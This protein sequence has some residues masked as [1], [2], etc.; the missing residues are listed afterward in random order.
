MPR[1]IETTVFSYAELGPKA[2]KKAKEWLSHWLFEGHEPSWTTELLEEDLEHHYG[3]SPNYSGSG[4]NHHPD[5]WW[6]YE[7][8]HVSFGACLDFKDLA[9]ADGCKPEASEILILVGELRAYD[10][11]PSVTFKADDRNHGPREIEVE[12]DDQ[13]PC[14][15]SDLNDY[16]V[17][18]LEDRK[19]TCEVRE[20]LFIE[21]AIDELENQGLV[22]VMQNGSKVE[23]TPGNLGV[24]AFSAYLDFVQAAEGEEAVKVPRH[25]LKVCSPNGEAAKDVL[26]NELQAAVKDWARE[27]CDGLRE[28]VDAEY[29]QF[30]DDDYLEE[31]FRDHGDE[32]E[33]T[34]DGE[35]ED[36]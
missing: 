27:V 36:I 23:A 33:F 1:V 32:F 25:A 28:T 18:W 30:S 31:Y 17:T 3:V 10:V 19:E 2:Q 11:E 24:E 26:L 16:L 7:G 4:K 12:T 5:L 6:S 15:P 21:T 9:E 20:L 34:E 29:E 22:V 35:R 13:R 14:S 8:R